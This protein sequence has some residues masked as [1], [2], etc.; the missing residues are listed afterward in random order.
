MP[1][2]RFPATLTSI[3]GIGPAIASGL[4]AEIGDIRRFDKEAQLAKFAGLV[5]NPFE[6]S[7]FKAE[8][9]RLSKTG[10]RYLRYYL[11]EGANLVRM[12]APEFRAFHRAQTPGSCQAPSQTCFG[13]YRQKARRACLCPAEERPAL[14]AE[15][16]A[17]GKHVLMRDR[18]F[19]AFLNKP[20]GNRA[21]IPH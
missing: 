9:R 20:A 2:K 16:G 4:L 11:I 15:G 21:H 17:S 8:E 13:A 18:S 5:W 1:L 3:P 6:S 14:C 7:D 12:H 19:P 10:N